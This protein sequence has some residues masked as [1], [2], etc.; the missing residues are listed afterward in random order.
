MKHFKIVFSGNFVGDSSLCA[1]S[2]AGI[3]PG[4]LGLSGLDHEE[5]HPG[6]SESL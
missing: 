6:I 5:A 4:G 2:L 3:P 1:A